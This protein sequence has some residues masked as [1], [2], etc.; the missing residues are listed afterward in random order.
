MS[1]MPYRR[2]GFTITPPIW[3]KTSG[4]SSADAVPL[5]KLR[6]SFLSLCECDAGHSG[7]AHPEVMMMHRFTSTLWLTHT[8]TRTVYITGGTGRV[9]RCKLYVDGRQFGWLAGSTK[10]IVATKA[11]PFFLSCSI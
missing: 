5:R 9:L 10:R 7:A 8:A 6:C 2:A 4:A 11:N 1:P 3:R